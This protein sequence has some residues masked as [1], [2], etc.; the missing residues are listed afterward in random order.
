MLRFLIFIKHHCKFLWNLA[1][2]GNGILVGCSTVVE[3]FL[4][5]PVF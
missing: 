4:L 2:Y 1:E 3:L 5:F